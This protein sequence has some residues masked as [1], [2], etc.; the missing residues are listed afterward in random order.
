MA[1]VSHS[2]EWIRLGTAAPPL[3][4]TVLIK[5]FL[6]ALFSRFRRPMNPLDQSFL[7]PLD[8]NILSKNLGSPPFIAIDG[9]ANVRDM[10]NLQ[11]SGRPTRTGRSKTR[12]K[13]VLRSAQLSH[14]RPAGREALQAL[15]L[16]A[17]FDFRSKSEIELYGA[18]LASLP[19]TQVYH[20][21]VVPD[22]YL[23]PKEI[24]RREKEYE[25]VGD[26][27]LLNEYKSFLEHGGTSFGTVFR[28]MRDHPNDLILVHCAIGK[29]RTGLFIALLLMLVGVPDEAICH[30]YA[31]SRVGLEPIRNL[32]LGY[33]KETPPV[34]CAMMG[35]KH[36]TMQKTLSIIRHRYGGVEGYLS[37][38]CNMSSPEDWDIIRRSFLV[39]AS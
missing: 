32:I 3:S 6:Q 33:M 25:Q 5:P 21:P 35:S 13:R 22:E 7:I 4:S 19:G 1:I 36:S 14:L 10:G 27:A 26:E 11:A 24:E 8:P 28:Y 30:D 16:K 39:P 20:V 9:A 29:D 2:G 17:V 37:R 12:S 34:C 18:P 23:D 31:L 38:K 15:N